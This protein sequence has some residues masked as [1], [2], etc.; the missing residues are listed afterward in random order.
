VRLWFYLDWALY[1][2]VFC[3]RSYSGL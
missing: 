2:D 3:S 1:K